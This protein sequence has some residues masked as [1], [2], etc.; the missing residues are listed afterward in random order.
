MPRF[1]SSITMFLAA[2]AS[3]G[4]NTAHTVAIHRQGLTTT[5]SGLL[6]GR[7][8]FGSMGASDCLGDRDSKPD[9][10][11]ERGQKSVEKRGLRSLRHGL[12]EDKDISLTPRHPVACPA[13]TRAPEH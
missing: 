12:P 8:P 9:K 6:V 11:D 13:I 7:A 3:G 1:V 10:R 2:R 5:G 4:I